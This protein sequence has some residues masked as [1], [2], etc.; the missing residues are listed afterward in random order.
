MP[1]IVNVNL[2]SEHETY[3]RLFITTGG[4]W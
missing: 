3:L 2:T 4:G 1:Q